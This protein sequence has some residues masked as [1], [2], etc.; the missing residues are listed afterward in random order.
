MSAGDDIARLA[1][2]LR[3]RLTWSQISG[4]ARLAVRRLALVFS[5]G[6]LFV[7]LAALADVALARLP[8]A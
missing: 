3:R 6:V 4:D 1:T 5:G 2:R 7:G 8:G